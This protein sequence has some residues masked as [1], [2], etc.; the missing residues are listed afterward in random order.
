MIPHGEAEEGT[1]SREWWRYWITKQNEQKFGSNCEK[2][3]SSERGE[4]ENGVQKY[5]SNLVLNK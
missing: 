5:A 2:Y 4:K 1:A 3:V